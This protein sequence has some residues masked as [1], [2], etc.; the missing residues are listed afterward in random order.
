M[1]MSQY[2][3]PSLL[4]RLLD[5]EPEQTRDRPMTA[6]QSVAA[7]RHGVQRDLE[8]LL[9]ARRRWRSWPAHLEHLGVSSVGYGIAD[10][11][12]GVLNDPTQRDRL[13]QEIE[14]AIRR[15]EPRFARLRVVAMDAQNSLE[16]RLRLRIEAL[17]RV[18]EGDE[19]VAYETII[20]TVAA[21]V[22]VRDQG[23][24]PDV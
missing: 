4:D 21:T 8:A 7:L 22:T 15:Y 12:S 2:A 1:V 23:E 3:R 20:D 24:R 19:P 14:T 13:C 18:E 16:P 11:A 17:L 9:N 6:A 5:W 10:F